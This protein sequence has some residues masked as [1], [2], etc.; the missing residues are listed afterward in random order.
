MKFAAFLLATTALLGP[1]ADALAEDKPQVEVI[2]PW[3]SKSESA[4]VR[5]LA[6]GVEAAGGEWVD[7]ATQSDNTD[8]V[9]TNRMIGGN[10]PTSFLSGGLGSMTSLTEQ[11]LLGDVDAAMTA[12][13]LD[14]AMPEEIVKDLK[15]D[16]HYR[17]VPI[18]LQALNAVYYSRKVLKDAGVDK[19]PDNWIDMFAAF[20]KIK[21]NGQTPLALGAQ[22]WQ[23]LSL[24]DTIM[25]SIDD[26]KTYRKVFADKDIDAINSPA[27]KQGVETFLKLR[28][29]V[30]QAST[31]RS[32][33]DT[34]ALIITDKA[35]FQFI[36]DYA[37]GEFAAAGK[38]SETDF[39]CGVG[40]GNRVI[41]G[42]YDG[43]AMPKASKEAAAKAQ[44]LFANVVLDPKI[45]IEFN[46]K[47]GS[48]P[49]RTDLDPKLLPTCSAI[50]YELIKDPAKTVLSPYSYFSAQLRG[51]IQDVVASAWSNP[52]AT[53]DALI[54]SFAST[55]K[56]NL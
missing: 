7:A 56:D 50:S 14:K 24:F 43:F 34:T 39:G 10:P 38:S 35:G 9:A 12:G 27:F 53:A 1:T 33:N 22:G 31:G 23:L 21:K 30:D 15:I 46:R 51:E 54:A 20:D 49:S 41:I 29:Y 36:G 25:A 4:A 6:D 8:T 5:V 19:I 42:G 48:M 45:Q 13:Q 17:A 28:S 32:W 2:H 26:G 37:N 55:M 52:S 18:S 40:L 44:A 16:G 47:K 3:T 11:G